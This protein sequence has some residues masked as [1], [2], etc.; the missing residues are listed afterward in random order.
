MISE[1]ALETAIRRKLLSEAQA[2]GLR[3][4]EAELARSG[5]EPQDEEKLR[6]VSGFGDIFV[7]IG[8]L[9]FLGATGY[10]GTRIAGDPAGAFIIAVASWLLAEFFTRIRR[11][12]LPSIVL[13]VSFAGAVFLTLL[14]LITPDLRVSSDSAKGLAFVGAG[15]GTAVAALL[16]YARFHVPITV[17]A[18]A[19][20]LVAIFIGVLEVIGLK[21]S[22]GA[23]NPVLF[24]SG[25]AVF[26][27]AMRFDSADP[28][29]VTRRT[30][31]AFWLHLLAAPLIVHPLV[32]GI[33]SGEEV[34][35]ARAFAVLGVFLLLGIVAVLVNRRAILVS[36]LAYAGAAF[37]SL[38]DK[39]GLSDSAMPLTLLAL[40]AFVLLL[41]AG[42]TLV[43]TKLLRLV[44][45][46]YRRSLPP[47]LAV[48]T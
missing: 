12:A 42:W 26:A 29:R 22:D 38:I 30:D 46:R 14:L 40:G 13:L 32:S 31:I 5:T 7:T 20:A 41:S 28:L 18:G 8:L 24:V 9:L 6:F 39:V 27:A 36:A 37:G 33:W 25:L 43:R 23:L 3:T 16:H 21:M 44:P 47:D 2:D 11:M 45:E 48:P 35:S 15:L 10:F 19:A 34:S 17:A 4:I 1:N